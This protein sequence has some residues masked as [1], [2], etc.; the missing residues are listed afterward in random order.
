MRLHCADG[1]GPAWEWESRESRGT[2]GISTGMEANVAGF[3]RWWK[4]VAG[5]PREWKIW[6]E[7][8]FT[9]FRRNVA[10]WDFYDASAL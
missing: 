8:Q 9:G 4:I 10:V 6:N 2:Y 3:P 7:K 1:N 5:L